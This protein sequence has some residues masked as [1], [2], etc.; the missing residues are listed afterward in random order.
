MDACRGHLEV[1]GGVQA[2]S[3]QH[4]LGHMSLLAS[5]SGMLSAFVGGLRPDSQFQPK[6]VEFGKF[7]EGPI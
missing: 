3:E 4:D 1:Q 7:Q 6:R 5:E 2:E